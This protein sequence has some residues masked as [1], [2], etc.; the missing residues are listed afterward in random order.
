M[1]DVVLLQF[2][3]ETGL[4]PPIGILP[5]VVRQHLFGRFIFGLGLAVHF[6]HM[7]AS[8]TAEQIA[9]YYIPGIII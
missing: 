3:L 2:H 4:S 8:M 7:L 6:Q 5:A 9:A 1:V